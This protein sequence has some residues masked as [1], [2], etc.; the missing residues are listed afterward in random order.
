MERR[1]VFSRNANFSIEVAS[2]SAVKK[3]REASGAPLMDCKNAL[4]NANGDIQKALDWLRSKGI[5][6]VS[7][8]NRETKEG[9]IGVYTN[10]SNNTVTLV[11][12]NCE[13]GMRLSC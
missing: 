11:E 4:I 7:S 2:A 13:T 5:S 10:T 9:L 1:I 12:V 6:K 8:S 3:L